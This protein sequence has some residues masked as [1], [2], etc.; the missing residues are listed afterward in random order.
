MFCIIPLII[1]VGSR[2]DLPVPFTTPAGVYDASSFGKGCISQ[3]TKDV[4]QL[5]IRT[6]VVK[7]VV[8]SLQGA[9]FPESEDCGQPGTPSIKPNLANSIIGLTVN[10][11]KPEN[12]S[13]AA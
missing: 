4:T 8:D 7:Q 1:Y 10:I 5:P 3:W 2:F 6:P 13:P 11:I 9:L 12:L